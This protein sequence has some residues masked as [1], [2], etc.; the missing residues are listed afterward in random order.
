M[1]V[2]YCILE[3]QL[4]TMKQFFRAFINLVFPKLCFMCMEDSPA[5]GSNFCFSCKK[6]LPFT[7]DFK[8]D[9]STSKNRLE[10]RFPVLHACALFNFY[11]HSYV[12]T[13]MHSVK[14]GGRQ[15]IGLA[16][17]K[18]L[19]RRARESNKF[20]DVYC[21]VPVPLHA[22][23]MAQRGYNQSQVIA[24]GIKEEMGISIR[25]DFIYKNRHTESQTSKG[26]IERVS[27]VSQSFVCKAIP[28]IDGKHIIIVDDVLTTGATIEALVI[29]IRNKADVKISVLTV[30]VA[31]S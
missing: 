21:L 24:E 3:A 27:N 15:D 30:C 5:H 17:G 12:R 13:M 22:S 19:G 14:Y 10:Y 9:L 31:Q 11:P 20:K 18:M 28:D 25:N 16:L 29:A 1:L 6:E 23:R 2:K 8:S 26:R 4:H 7:V